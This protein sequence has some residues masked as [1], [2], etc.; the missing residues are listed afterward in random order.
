MRPVS[1]KRQEL[2]KRVK[3]IRDALREEVG[4]CE[5]CGKTNGTLDVHEIGRGQF[6]VLC[7]GERCALLIVCRGCHSE[8]L[9]QPAEWTEARQLAVL[10]MSRPR[11]FSL[12]R[13]LE[14]TSP[15]AMRRIEIPEVLRWMQ[16]K[17]LTKQD[18]AE[19][20]KVDRR[21]VQN[22]IAS[23]QLPAMDCRIVGASKPLYRVA[24]SDYLEFCK[25]RKVSSN[26]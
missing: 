6:R 24:W 3:P 22:W 8:K 10:A 16:G 4:C 5:I 2:M 23:G 9:S 14:I 26:G 25:T 18:I 11:D 21:S 13:F 7:L 19:N 17:Y 1:K 15:R 20:L 12:A